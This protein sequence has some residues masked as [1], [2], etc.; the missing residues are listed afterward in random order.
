MA[1][2]FDDFD[3]DMNELHD[4]YPEYNDM[5]SEELRENYNNVIDQQHELLKNKGP[6]YR[7]NITNIDECIKR[8]DYV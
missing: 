8:I 6:N 2:G 4:L 1:E 3:F 5:D 7:R